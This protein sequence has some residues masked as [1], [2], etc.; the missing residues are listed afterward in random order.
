MAV[1]LVGVPG[2]AEALGPL[3]GGVGFGVDGLVGV[4]QVSLEFSSLRW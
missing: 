2:A 3:D 1:A 4:D